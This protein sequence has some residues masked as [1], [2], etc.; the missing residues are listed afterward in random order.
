MPRQA[1]GVSPMRPTGPHIRAS[2]VF[3]G[4]SCGA[5]GAGL[6]M[7]HCVYGLDR[8]EPPGDVWG[9]VGPAH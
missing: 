1:T 5:D 8:L 7:P 3:A 6:E 9:L 2:R 4:E